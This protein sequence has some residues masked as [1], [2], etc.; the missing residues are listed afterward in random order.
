MSPTV[1]AREIA[2]R[3]L[4]RVL[5]DGAFASASLD[6]E[7]NKHGQLDAR[8]RG[9]AT[10][11]VYGTLRTYRSLLAELSKFASKGLPEDDTAFIVPLTITAYQVL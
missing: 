11:L 2:V 10:E 9:L 7:L 5:R 6:A 1:D 4:T 3:V 8:D